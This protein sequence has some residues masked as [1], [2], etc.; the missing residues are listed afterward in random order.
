MGNKSSKRGSVSGNSQRVEKDT[1]DAV[2]QQLA[3]LS[4]KFGFDKVEVKQ[5]HDAFKS[6][7]QGGTVDR[8]AFKRALEMLEKSGLKLNDPIFVDRLFT[9][10]DKDQNNVLDMNEFIN[11]LS[12]LCKGTPEEKLELS[13]KSYDLDGNGFITKD[14]LSEMFAQAWISGFNALRASQAPNMP[15]EM[16]TEDFNNFSKEMGAVFAESAFQNLDKNKDGKLS[17]DEF[18]EFAMA[19]PKITATLNGFKKDVPIM[20]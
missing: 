2:P 16:N 10:M 1:V 19:E 15:L 18:K 20:L 17:F 9:V 4:N 11:G 13:F 8:A 14:E 7:S 12:L 5:L 6:V 3:L